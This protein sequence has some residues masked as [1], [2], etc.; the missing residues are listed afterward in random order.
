[1]PNPAG[2]KKGAFDELF[3]LSCTSA[4]S[5]LAV[6]TAE[7]LGSIGKALNEVLSWNGTKWA[8]VAVPNPE[9][10]GPG[11]INSLAGVTCS[12]ARDCWAVGFLDGDVSKPTRNQALHWTGGKWKVVLTPNPGGKGKG[13]VSALIGVRCAS[14]ADCWAV[15]RQERHNSGSNQD[16]VL[17][18]NGTKWVVS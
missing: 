15:G 1:M 17:H 2:A 18:W 4:K 3:G 8:K 9:G 13:D 6:G 16:Q 14:P 10:T 11:S 5:C 7:N 12:A